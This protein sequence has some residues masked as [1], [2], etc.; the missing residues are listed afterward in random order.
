MTIEKS[1]K[2]RKAVYQ[3]L[4]GKYLREA[5]QLFAKKDYPQ[6]SEKLWGAAAETVKAVA[7]RRGLELGTHA[8][9]WEFVSKLDKEHPD[10]ML[11]KDFSYA[12]NLHQN[13][14]EDWLGKEYIEEGLQILKNFV[15]K[16]Q[17]LL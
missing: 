16:L 1:L 9:L 11:K 5:E 8:S 6:A 10:W 15:E 12:G 13:F 3:R 4:N 17:S 14:Y 2:A 7:A